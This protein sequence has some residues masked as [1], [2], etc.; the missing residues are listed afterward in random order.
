MT[1]LA[2]LL[3]LTHRPALRGLAELRMLTA[4]VDDL[5]DYIM[6]IGC[7]VEDDAAVLVSIQCVSVAGAFVEGQAKREK[8]LSLLQSYQRQVGWPPYDL[9]LELQEKWQST[10]MQV[11]TDDGSMLCSRV[12]SGP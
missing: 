3:L 5:T 8:V 4:S 2:R 1:A 6:G 12:R 9:G 7:T 10:G 11:S